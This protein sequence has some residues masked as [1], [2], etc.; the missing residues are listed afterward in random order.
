MSVAI[1]MRR[2][3]R[4]GIPKY[5]IVATPTRSKRDGRYL[6]NLGTFNPKDKKGG[7]LLRMD[8]YEKWIQKGAVPSVLLKKLY[9]QLKKQQAATAA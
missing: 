8:A 1:R 5:R 7:L 3:G 6:E 2:I 4:R 9:T